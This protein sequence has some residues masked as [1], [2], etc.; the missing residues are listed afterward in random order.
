MQVYR[1]TT[2]SIDVDVGDGSLAGGHSVADT[3]TIDIPMESAA[4]VSN[5]V[6]ATANVE[7]DTP[8]VDSALGVTY[9]S[10]TGPVDGSHVSSVFAGSSV[11]VV[12]SVLPVDP[13]PPISFQA[14]S[15][16]CPLDVGAP[17]LSDAVRTSVSE[18]AGSIA[19]DVYL[20]GAQAS[21]V[22]MTDQSD[23]NVGGSLSKPI[24]DSTAANSNAPFK[25]A[26]ELQKKIDEVAAKNGG[27][28]PAS[29]L[30]LDVQQPEMP[31]APPHASTEDETVETP[32]FVAGSS[33]P[34]TDAE[35]VAQFVI[36]LSY[37]LPT[38]TGK[39]N[40]K[41]HSFEKDEA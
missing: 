1:W 30:F 18:T 35:D 5:E 4:P 24:T 17:I 37:A 19:H 26:S 3:T 2:S 33:S 6:S 32:G 15:I 11:G 29:M 27:F 25:S 7:V 41:I 10:S 14:G 9:G 38:S 8:L 31:D 22:V 21:P 20:P 40:K 12:G 28:Y 13:I 39:F 34:P 16:T 36:P 23:V